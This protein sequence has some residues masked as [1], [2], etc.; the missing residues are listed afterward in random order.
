VRNRGGRATCDQ[1]QTFRSASRRV[2]R[3]K[4]I[5]ETPIV[6]VAWSR[7]EVRSLRFD[8]ERGE[9]ADEHRAEEQRSVTP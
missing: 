6:G 9:L 1:T 4:R 3:R 7:L 5:S 8:L 2:A